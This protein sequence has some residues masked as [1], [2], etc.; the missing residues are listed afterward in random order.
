MQLFGTF[1]LHPEYG[2]AQVKSINLKKYIEKEEKNEHMEA[3]KRATTQSMHHIK[4]CE[5]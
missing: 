1:I 2:D 4:S 5:S 3:N